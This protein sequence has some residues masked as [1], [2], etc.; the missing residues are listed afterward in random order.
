MSPFERLYRVVARLVLP[1][2]FRRERGDELVGVA[3][4]SGRHPVHELAALVGA[5]MRLRTRGTAAPAAPREWLPDGLRLGVLLTLVALFGSTN[6]NL[7]LALSPLQYPEVVGTTR[8]ATDAVWLAAIVL[9]GLRRNTLGAIVLTGLAVASY[10]RSNIDAVQAGRALLDVPGHA[11][12]TSALLLLACA[13]VMIAVA[14]L[15]HGRRSAGSLMWGTLP[16]AIAGVHRMV[17]VQTEC[18]NPPPFPPT[19]AEMQHALWCSNTVFAR[20]D[21]IILI[22]V[23]VIAAVLGVTHLARNRSVTFGVAMLLLA[24]AVEIGTYAQWQIAAG[25][26]RLLFTSTALAAIALGMLAVGYGR[27]RTPSATA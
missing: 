7:Y 8:L 15:T 11:T 13:F 23:L 19:N 26:N 16:F 17:L 25:S 2:A 14:K 21:V 6:A 24:A 5:G 9:I 12:Y 4:A 1:P 22:T 10:S 3:I 27:D 18:L 20:L